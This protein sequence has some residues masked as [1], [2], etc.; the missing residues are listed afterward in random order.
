MIRIIL[1][2]IIVFFTYRLVYKLVNPPVI[3]GPSQ[4][5]PDS[6]NGQFDSKNVEEGRFKDVK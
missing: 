4:A 3:K 2:M 6:L 1:I 5:K